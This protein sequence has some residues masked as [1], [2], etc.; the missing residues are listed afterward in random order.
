MGKHYAGTAAALAAIDVHRE[1]ESHSPEKN[2]NTSLGIELVTVHDID[3]G[4][5]EN[6]APVI[7][8]VNSLMAEAI[9]RGASD[10]H[11]EP[12]E[13]RFRVRIRVDGTL[14]EVTEIPAD[15]KRAVIARI[16]VMS[17]MDITES[18]VP[19]DGRIKLKTQM[20]D[21]DFRV[22]SL[23]TIFGEKCVLRLLSQGNLKLDINKLGFSKKQ[24][25]VF[26][27]GVYS[28]NGMVLVTGPTGS[29]KT[30]TLYSA[31]NDLNQ[32]SDNISTAED[33]V[34]YNLS[35]IN[36]VQVNKDVGL[37][38]ASV[39]RALLRQDP[40]IILVGEI[41][42]F[43]TAEIAIQA[44]LTGHLVLSTLH[45]NDAPSSITRLLNMGVEPFLIIAA[46]NAIV[47]QRLVRTICPACKIEDSITKEQLILAGI[48]K[49]LAE[50]M[51]C[52]TGKGCPKC[53]GSGFKGRAAIYEVFDF[54]PTLKEMVLK[55][56]T[57]IALKKQAVIEGMQTLRISALTKVVEGSTSFQE[58]ISSTM[59]N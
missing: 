14:H 18:R 59:E 31:I 49:E 2:E 32:V 15:F 39:L 47:A 37:T 26:K 34:E 30:T 46:L 29:G 25:E 23:P 42:D 22:N 11:I 44:A 36:Q 24:L 51:R 20:G 8:L 1:K 28:P 38:F 54:T 19:Q 10:I 21:V 43:E 52:F 33:P 40:D 12:Y 3:S 57:M 56:E 27:K 9:R 48:S 16:K 41:R 45:T 55:G 5:R 13:K 6:D 17:R 53:N 35:G 7:K 58:A 4:A 50:Q